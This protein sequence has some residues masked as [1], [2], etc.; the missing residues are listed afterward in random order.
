MVCAVYLSLAVGSAA[1]ECSE[2]G[3]HTLTTFLLRV[4]ELICQV[5]KEVFQI[6]SLSKCSAPEERELIMNTDVLISL[7]LQ[8]LSPWTRPSLTS[9][10]ETGL[11]LHQKALTLDSGR[12]E[13]DR[14]IIKDSRVAVGKGASLRGWEVLL[15]PSLQ[16][17]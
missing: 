1:L 8:G 9:E 7:L 12:G 6:P 14:V 15:A 3:K 13:R 5:M 2:E 16:G 11:I 17:R 10:P 4:L